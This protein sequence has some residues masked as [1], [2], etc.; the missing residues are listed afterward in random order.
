[1]K[2]LIYL[3]FL[4]S[5]SSCSQDT[6]I[7]IDK[8]FNSKNVEKLLESN[9]IEFEKENINNTM[10]YSFGLYGEKIDSTITNIYRIHY[11]IDWDKEEA[12]PN[13]YFEDIP[14]RTPNILTNKKGKAIIITAKIGN[15]KPFDVK[16]LGVFDNDQVMNLKKILTS[17]Y[18]KPDEEDPTEIYGIWGSNYGYSYF[19]KNDNF[20]IRLSIYNECFCKKAESYSPKKY[21]THPKGGRYGELTI[22][23]NINPKFYLN[24]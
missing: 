7:N 13:L 19:W 3:L 9:L 12:Y 15:E 5:L 1:M 18:G 11:T 4:L 16:E 14:L 22:Y 23:N 6:R 8:V 21:K 24:D 10:N 2:S 17:K 20:L